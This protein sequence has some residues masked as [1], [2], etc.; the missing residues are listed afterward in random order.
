MYIY[1]VIFSETQYLPSRFRGVKRKRKYMYV[2]ADILCTPFWKMHLERP[3]PLNKH[4][5]VATWDMAPCAELNAVKTERN[6]CHKQERP[7][8]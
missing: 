3:F 8:K 4:E 1:A 2:I 7:G 6:S 5:S